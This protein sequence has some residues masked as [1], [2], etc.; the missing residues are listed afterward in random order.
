MIKN[1][2]TVIV[3]PTNSCN[4]A[5][6]Y[7]YA[8]SED[9]QPV[10]DDNTLENT[11]TKIVKQQGKETVIN[12]LWHG[13]EPLLM[14]LDFYTKVVEI[15]KELRDE[16][17][18]IKNSMQTNGTLLT[19]KTLDFLLS[20]KF[21]IGVS[22]DGPKEINDLTRVYP[23][24]SSSF[25]QT[26]SALHLLKE[27]R[28]SAGVVAVI[29]STN[30]HQIDKLYDFFQ[31]E[32]I[33][34]KPNPLL[35]MG[36]AGNNNYLEITPGEYATS[37]L[38]IFNNTLMDSEQSVNI[39]ILND[40]MNELLFNNS[41]SC[42]HSVNC[43]ENFIAI[44]ASGDV[45]PCGRFDHNNLEFKYGNINTDTFEEI[46]QHPMRQKILHERR[47]LEE[48]QPCDY[49]SLCNSGCMHMALLT[50]GDIFQKD[51][52]C[53]EYIQLYSSIR[54]RLISELAEAIIE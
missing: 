17:Y 44:N 36:R 52:H 1:S 10:M 29:N 23:D 11:I 42:N 28:G 3:K 19:E 12:F 46:L 7:C 35:N 54:E 34:F 14:G 40:T 16:G 32:G 31:R 43:Q 50:T 22:L 24:G 25:N 15:E 53:N 5:C 39:P 38:Q 26:I 4:L 41:Y 49:K 9:D 18:A 20:E 13:G 6:K 48:C 45:F 33:S 37:M 2:L 30:V 21:N 47:D 27:K 8:D 51:G